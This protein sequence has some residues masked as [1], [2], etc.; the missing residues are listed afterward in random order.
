MYITTLQLCRSLSGAVIV[1]RSLRGRACRRGFNCAAPFRERLLPLYERHA[2]GRSALQLCRSLSGAVMLQYF[3]WALAVV[4]LQLCRSLS[5]AVMNDWSGPGPSVSLLQLCRSLS[6]AVIR[7]G[8]P[9]A[10]GRIR[11][12]NCAAPFRERLYESCDADSANQQASIVPLPFGSGYRR[13]SE[14]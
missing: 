3:G 2:A 1:R 5:G 9:S 4:P 6:G 13:R 14:P 8:R 7:G 11:C 12:F 10:P